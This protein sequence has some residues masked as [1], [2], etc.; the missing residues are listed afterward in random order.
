MPS[1]KRRF[2]AGLFAI[3]LLSAGCVLIHSQARSSPIWF[4]LEKI[5]FHLEND[6]TPA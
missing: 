6:S 3:L 1:L 5:P 4:E 2:C